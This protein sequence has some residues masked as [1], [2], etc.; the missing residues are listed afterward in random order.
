[1]N[2]FDLN[3]LVGGSVGG[4]GAEETGRGDTCWCVGEARSPLRQAGQFQPMVEP[5]AQILRKL[6][7]VREEQE[8]CT[9]LEQV[10]HFSESLPTSWEH[11][12]QG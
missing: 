12:E 9:H 6:A 2:P 1:M 7:R 10:E 4:G 11:M 3:M 8:K 5:T